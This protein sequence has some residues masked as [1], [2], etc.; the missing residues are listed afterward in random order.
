MW[1]AATI[2]TLPVKGV[3]ASSRPPVEL[4]LKT[5]FTVVL[6]TMKWLPTCCIKSM[7][8]VWWDSQRANSPTGLPVIDPDISNSDHGL[9]Q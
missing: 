3:K 1:L 6:K 7:C 5:D 9:Q 2:H 4:I 8:D